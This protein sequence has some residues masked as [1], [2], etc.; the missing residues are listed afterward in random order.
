V[1]AWFVLNWSLT[2]RPY[3]CKGRGDEY[4][5][6]HVY[7]E[8]VGCGALQKIV[9][10]FST[11]FFD[12]RPWVQR[13]SE[14]VM[15]SLPKKHKFLKMSEGFNHIPDQFFFPRSN[16]PSF[17][18]FNFVDASG[19]EA[20]AVLAPSPNAFPLFFPVSR[21]VPTFG[22]GIAD[23]HSPRMLFVVSDRSR[24]TFWNVIL[25]FR[26]GEGSHYSEVI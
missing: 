19:E 24:S 5:H 1:T 26:L 4:S 2:F 23:L 17:S 18:L 16:V 13:G 9:L 14:E 12:L 25:T 21:S 20:C 3:R 22:N 6:M 10:K 8:R 15:C 11:F 7:K